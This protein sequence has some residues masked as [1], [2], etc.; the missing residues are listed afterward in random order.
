M[1]P[2]S[3]PIRA[4]RPIGWLTVLAL[5][6]AAPAF[7]Q[8][9]IAAV[10]RAL[11]TR[12]ELTTEAKRLEASAARNAETASL[13]ARARARLAEGDFRPGDLI[14]LDVQDEPTLS[15]TFAVDGNREL[16]LPAPTVGTLSLVGVLRSEAPEKVTEYIGRFVQA[17]VVKVSPLIRLTIQGEVVRAGVYGVPADA[18]LADALMASGG[19]TAQADFKKVRVERDGRTIMDA[20][21][22][23]Q[24][25]ADGRTIDA[26]LLKNGDRLVIARRPDG[27]RENLRFVWIVVSLAGGVYGLSR[28]F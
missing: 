19:A 13:L 6:A 10:E 3:I 20:R 26:A 12:A 15:D 25:L 18:V 2:S 27:F 8:E 17:P 28:A 11:A 24:A 7:G 23:S 22:L 21:T 5:S 14:L 1:R 9:P 16:R 4:T